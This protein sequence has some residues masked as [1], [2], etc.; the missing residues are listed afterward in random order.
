VQFPVGIV[1]N[2]GFRGCFLLI[3]WPE[4]EVDHSSPF[5]VELKNKWSYTYTATSPYVFVACGGTALPSSQTRVRHTSG[6]S[7]AGRLGVNYKLNAWNLGL[8]ARHGGTCQYPQH[9]QQKSVCPDL[10]ERACCPFLNRLLY[11][12][13]VFVFLSIYLR[14]P[15]CSIILCSKRTCMFKCRALDGG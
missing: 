5:S 9:S 8:R 13:A 14:F 4:R 10:P 3:R 7:K 15:V 1:N 12:A 11:N 2:S 6:H